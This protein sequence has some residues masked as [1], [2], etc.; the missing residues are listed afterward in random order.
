MNGLREKLCVAK[1]GNERSTLYRKFTSNF[2]LIFLA[3]VSLEV[4]NMN[5]TY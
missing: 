4:N 2:N 3:L 5:I 1:Q